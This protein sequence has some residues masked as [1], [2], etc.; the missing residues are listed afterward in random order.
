MK[1]SPRQAAAEALLLVNQE[2]GYSNV[3]FNNKIKSSGLSGKDSAF[4]GALFYGTLER[5]LTLDHV[6]AKYS[7]LPMKR[8]SPAV[9]EILRISLYQLLYL[10]S[11]PESAAVNEG[12]KLARAMGVTSASGFI[13]GVLR[14][15]L[16]DGKAIPPV[17][18]GKVQ[19]LSVAY[20]C[21]Q[22]LVE[23]LLAN[24]N[25]EDVL[26][27]LDHSLGRPELYARV[28]VTK[29]SLETLT[30]QLQEQGVL[31]Q[32]DPDLENC[33]IL[34]STASIEALPA[35]EQGM[36]HIQDKSSQLCAKMVDAKPGHKVVDVCSAPGSKAFTIA[37]GMDSQGQV[38]ACDIYEEKVKKIKEGA[39]RLGLTIVYPMKNDAVQYN[40]QLQGADRVLCDVPC[41]GLGIISRKPEIKYKKPEEL[42][43]LP[44]IQGDILKTSSQYLKTG[45]RL[46][47]S[48]CTVVPEENQLVVEQFLH[49][50]PEFE[51]E[52]LPEHTNGWYTTLFPNQKKT[53]GFFIATIKKIR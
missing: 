1:K 17:K 53:D 19:Q 9:R 20:S 16:R 22:W 43:G 50:H 13:N 45:G 29:T 38:I 39:A 41:S 3:V 7:K 36:F 44:Q 40:S 18:G 30:A 6:I 23:K 31:A 27:L 32:K 8:M 2:G 21:P 49:S 11:V 28:N 24:Y 10:S 15:F 52:Y 47:Y 26:S 4:A 51:P 46:V 25:E 12:V 14:S 42:S 35:F 34:S 5:Q 37:Q 48:T 33:L